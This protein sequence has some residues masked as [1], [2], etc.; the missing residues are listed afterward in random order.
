MKILHYNYSLAI[1]GIET[2]LVNIANVQAAEGH[3]VYIV[4]LWNKYDQSLLD[5]LDKRIHLVLIN[6]PSDSRNIYYY[7]K[8]NYYLT[9]INADIYHIHSARLVETIITP[10]VK[11][12]MCVT[13]HSTCDF[14]GSTS[15]KKFKHIYA[16][17]DSVKDDIYN[18]FHLESKRIY[19][20]IELESINNTLNRYSSN[21]G[22]FHIVQV[23]RLQHRVK[24]QHL[25]IE[26]VAKLVN[27]GYN[28]LK[29]DI[30]GDGPSM[31]YLKSLSV[32]LGVKENVRFLGLKSQ[33]YIFD[34]LCR[35]DLSVQP[36]ITEGFGLTVAEAIAA[37][38]PVLVS[39]NP[40][41]MEVIC[42]GK[43][44]M[45]FKIGDVDDCASKIKSII[46]KEY[47][48]QII[49]NAY[50]FVLQEFSVYNTALKYIQEYESIINKII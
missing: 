28:N 44:G 9:K 12:K 32:N 34:N 26:A 43:Y 45:F 19:N 14:F 42:H 38:V 10:F 48:R 29:L 24:G 36:S 33:D 2:M 5:R 13:Q 49:E 16:I 30:I 1:G 39:D 40:G 3:D 7:F 50:K 6:K 41:P 37:K 17:S 18:S 35:Y 20:G 11:S 22:L 25:L 46:T 8:A 23:G 27:D 21:D 15:L 47:D 31:E 4:V